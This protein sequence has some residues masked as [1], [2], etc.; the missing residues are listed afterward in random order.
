MNNKPSSIRNLGPA[1]DAVY[2]KAGIYTADEIRTLGADEAY[3]MLLKSGSRPH[4]IAFYALAMGLQGRPW[5]DCKGT[6]KD[7]L[8][9]RFEGIKARL[10]DT[11][12]SKTAMEMELEKLG[13]IKAD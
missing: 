9:V 11:P 1:T 12:I 13:V 5:N 7:T 2:A 10:K 8:K 4:F 3:F 6:E